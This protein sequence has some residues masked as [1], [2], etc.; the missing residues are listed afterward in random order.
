MKKSLNVTIHIK[1]IHYTL[2]STNS[3][4]YCFCLFVL[5]FYKTKFVTFY[6]IINSSRELNE[7][8]VKMDLTV[9]LNTQCHRRHK[10]PHLY[11]WDQVEV[12]G[13]SAN[14]GMPEK[15]SNIRKVSLEWFS[16][17]AI[18]LHYYAL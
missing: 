15:V 3:I 11:H 2:S 6:T 18:F 12:Q 14:L 10:V 17:K 13:H 1:D 8:K 16:I 9:L 4:L 7:K 5:L